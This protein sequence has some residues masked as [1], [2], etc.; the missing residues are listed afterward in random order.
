MEKIGKKLKQLQ[1]L[2]LQPRYE[3]THKNYFKKNNLFKVVNKMK[4][5]IR[6][7]NLINQFHRK[8]IKIY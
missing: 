2:G 7:K 3:V 8:I 6:I 5:I 4:K 1:V